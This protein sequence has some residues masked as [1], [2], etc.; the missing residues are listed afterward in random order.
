MEESGLVHAFLFDGEGG[1][2]ELSWEEI[3]N[4]SADNGTLWVHLSYTA[5]ETLTWLRENSGLDPLIVDALLSEETRPRSTVIG[6]GVLLTLRGV[7][8]NPGADLEDMVSLRIWAEE[9]RVITTRKRPLRSIADLRNQLKKGCGPVSTSDF[10]IK[11]AELLT[12]YIEVAVEGI[13]T[14][15]SDL[16]EVISAGDITLRSQISSIRRDAIILRRYIAPQREAITRI[17]IENVHWLSDK[18]KRL[19]HEIANSLIRI[20]EDLDSLRDRASIARE[21]LTNALSAQLNSRMYVLSIF[22]A[23]FL[24]LSFFTGLLGINVGGIP[25][26]TYKWAFMVVILLLL[27]VCICQFYYFR[28]KRWI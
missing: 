9:D 20:V 3:N 27:C 7:N 6:K 19:L 21:E 13:E 25:G 1:G 22:T 15:T 16:E 4:W 23:I 26:A 28:K 24:P 11:T 14:R 10:V 17:Q 12:S 18:D 5:T 8:H 2:R